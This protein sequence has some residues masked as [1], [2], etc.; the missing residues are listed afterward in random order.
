MPWEDQEEKKK[1]KQGSNGSCLAFIFHAHCPEE[2]CLAILLNCAKYLN[3]WHKH[4]GG[5]AFMVEQPDFT[6]PAGVKDRYIKMVQSHGAMQLSMGVAT[7]PGIVTATRK[8]MLHLTPD[9]NGQPRAPTEKTLMEILR[10]MEI[11]GKKVWLCINCKLSNGIHTGY[12][13]SV[14]DEIKTYVAAFIRFSAAQV[15][16]WLKHKGCLGKDVNRLIRKCLT[17][18]QQQ[19]VT[20]SKYIK[21]KGF[22]V[23]KD[24]NENYI[25]NAA[26]NLGLFD[27]SLGLSEKE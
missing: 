9:K 2:Q 26:N 8:F 27:M 20:K 10:L 12:F 21:E 6:T 23:M 25:I 24:S 16:Y 17:V 4:L 15:Y 19:K 7:I 13:S 18:D 3:L 5:V 22:A 1:K 14:V 11:E